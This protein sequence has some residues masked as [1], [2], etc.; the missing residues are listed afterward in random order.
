MLQREKTDLFQ[1]PL[2]ESGGVRQGA[3][4]SL[5]LCTPA[6]AFKNLKNYFP[7]IDNMDSITLKLL[8]ILA[9]AVLVLYMM[10]KSEA[11][12]PYNESQP[13]RFEKNASV[14]PVGPKVLKKPIATRNGS[15]LIA[16]ASAG[17]GAPKGTGTSVNTLPKPKADDGFGQFAPDPK[18]LTGQN[19]VDATRWV[20]LGAMTSRR[21][22]NR[23]IRGDVPIPKNNGISPFQQSTIEQQP[24]GKL[25]NC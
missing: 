9:I 15:A 10:K 1:T 13:S 21:N 19:F 16:A 11:F 7:A 20:S 5:F 22:I 2:Q 23:D 4:F 17:L 14:E 25:I 8:G 24:A 12:S 3:R 6:R 18:E